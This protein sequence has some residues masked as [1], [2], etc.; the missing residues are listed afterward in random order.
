M[1]IGYFG[2]ENSHTYAAAKAF[3][4]N[5]P[6]ATFIGFPS[7]RD[8]LG[9]V[10]RRCDLAVVPVENSIEGTVAETVDA[11]GGSGLLIA[12]ERVMPVRQSLVVINGGKADKI[13]KVYSHP[14]ALAQCREHIRTH[15]P[16]ATAH[17]VAF[18]SAALDLV[19]ETSAAIARTCKA[20]QEILIEDMGDAKGNCTR[21]LAVS[22]IPQGVGNKASV[23]FTLPNEPG[24]LVRVLNVLAV[25]NANMTKIESRPNKKQMGSYEFFIDFTFDERPLSG[26]LAALSEI[27]SV[28]FLGRYAE[29]KE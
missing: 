14:Q 9:A 25:W 5:Y 19:D 1:Q 2:D 20:G 24:A 4:A 7:V 21:F 18:T 16:K 8:T 17:A 10:G 26:I 11:L 27:T 6:G 28:T 3:A 13:E 23:T 15:L 29:W 12:A 22:R